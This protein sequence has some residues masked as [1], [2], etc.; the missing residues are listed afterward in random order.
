M[1]I[2]IPLFVI[3][4]HK[5]LMPTPDRSV[6]IRRELSAIREVLLK[7]ME[8][9]KMDGLPK[10]ST[11]N[12]PKWIED[13]LYL[14]KVMR[15]ET[16]FETLTRFISSLYRPWTYETRSEVIG[17]AFNSLPKSTII[18]WVSSPL[19]GN[20]IGIRKNGTFAENLKLK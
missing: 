3:H 1:Y 2:L 15:D 19:T 8:D 10:F 5:E 16:N 12:P 7:A 17:K 11:A 6:L 20:R 13:K 9:Q 14:G 18:I 4:Q